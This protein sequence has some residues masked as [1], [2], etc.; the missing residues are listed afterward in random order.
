MRIDPLASLVAQ[1]QLK[2]KAAEEPGFT[3]EW[4]VYE[5][6]LGSSSKGSTT[7]LMS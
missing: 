4:A 5:S 7:L 3:G 6:Q 1:C 2:D